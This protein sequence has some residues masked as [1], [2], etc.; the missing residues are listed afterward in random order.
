MSPG[1]VLVAMVL[2]AI[3]AAGVVW[4]FGRARSVAVERAGDP[5]EDERVLL[6]RAIRDLDEERAAGMLGDED[7][8]AMRRE[9]EV[10]AVAVL[11]ALEA[12]E[13]DGDDAAPAGL[14]ELRRPSHRPFPRG[15]RS[16][17]VGVVVLGVV[18]VAAVIPLLAGALGQRLPGEQITGQPAAAA[19]SLQYYEQQVQAHPKDPAL[20]MNL[21]Q[22][23]RQAGLIQQAAQQYVQ[24]LAFDPRNVQALTALGELLYQQGRTK[25]ALRA[26]D[27][28]L[29]ID[30]SYPEALFDRGL[31]LTRGLHRAA[32][33]RTALRAY[34]AAAPF[35]AHRA[36]AERLLGVPPATAPSPS[37]SA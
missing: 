10:R 34:L 23:Y 8:R 20:R 36:E 33:G 28:A 26:V 14:R 31:I 37:P 24:A 4:P 2:A 19:G 7:Y 15:S 1:I 35:G 27:R 18:L 16:R 22:A 29:A 17:T 30:A 25:P 6:L 11:R 5:L 12:R 9:A 21:A 13:G 32:S 3:A